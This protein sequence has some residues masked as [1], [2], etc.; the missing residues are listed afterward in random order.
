MSQEKKTYAQPLFP[1]SP[2]PGK[3]KIKYDRSEKKSRGRS[4]GFC[5]SRESL[6]YTLLVLPIS[7]M[8]LEIF[9]CHSRTW[10]VK[11]PRTVVTSDAREIL[12]LQFLPR[13]CRI[14]I[15][16]G[17]HGGSIHSRVAHHTFKRIVGVRSFQLLKTRDKPTR[18]RRL[19]PM[20]A[21]QLTASRC[22]TS[23]ECSHQLT[24][25]TPGW[26]G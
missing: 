4:I 10:R 21:F 3:K 14:G 5:R 24:P 6:L 17:H 11:L 13:L 18:G 7:Q 15:R 25:G 8:H 12:V 16:H 9:D 20:S 2:L 19:F 23:I 26:G 1:F 22:V